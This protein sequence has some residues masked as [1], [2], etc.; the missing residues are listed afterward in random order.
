MTLASLWACEFQRSS[1]TE[2]RCRDGAYQGPR[3]QVPVFMS[4]VVVFKPGD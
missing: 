4:Q 2:P 1:Y 3:V